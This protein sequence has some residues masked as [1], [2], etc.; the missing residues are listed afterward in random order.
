MANAVPT[1]GG[2]EGVDIIGGLVTEPYFDAVDDREP[3]VPCSLPET[4]HPIEPVVV[5]DGQSFVL[6]LDSS[7]DDV[8]WMRR[9]VEEREVCMAMKF[10]ITSHHPPDYIEHMFD[11]KEEATE[12]PNRRSKTR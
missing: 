1:L 10:G 5:G 4:R 12:S 7:F 3:A 9:S 6:Q 11:A 8:F 2:L